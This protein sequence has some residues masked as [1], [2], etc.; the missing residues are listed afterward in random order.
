MRFSLLTVQ[1]SFQGINLFRFWK[2]PRRLFDSCGVGTLG[3][4][5]SKKGFRQEVFFVFSLVKV[6]LIGKLA[7]LI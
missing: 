5:K 2:V 6:V 1:S 4:V 3:N 7:D